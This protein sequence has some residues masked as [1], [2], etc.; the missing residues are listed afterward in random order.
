MMHNT[1]DVLHRLSETLIARRH[2]DPESSYTAQ[3]FAKGPDSILKKIGEE[4]AELIMAGKEGNKLN[5][6]RESA[7]AVSR[8]G[9]A[10]LQR[11]S[12]DDLL[13][14]MRRREG[15]SGVD[16]K[17]RGYRQVS[18][19]NCIFCRI[20]RGEIPSKVYEDEEMLAFNDISLARPVHILVIPEAAHRIAGARHRRRCAAARQDARGCQPAGDRA[21]SPDG[22]RVLINTGRIGHQE[23]AHL[24]I[25]IVGGPEPVSRC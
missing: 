9:A 19:A 18:D 7:D 24:H 5:V 21:G 1:H 3:L 22:F 20:V 13:Q 25:H 14:E 15:I 6:V 23:V 4:C 8:D 2:A 10:R 17:N 11:P 12:I 16:E